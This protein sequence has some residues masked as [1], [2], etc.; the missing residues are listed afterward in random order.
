ME[1]FYRKLLFESLTRLVRLQQNPD[2]IDVSSSSMRLNHVRCEFGLHNMVKLVLAGWGITYNPTGVYLSYDQWT[3][4]GQTLQA[5]H[6]THEYYC[7]MLCGLIQNLPDLI[8][9]SLFASLSLPGDSCGLWGTEAEKV[10]LLMRGPKKQKT[11][12]MLFEQMEL[13]F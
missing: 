4:K 6:D 7:A 12:S 3:Q 9:P 11:G 2:I 8:R 13:V 5:P 1:T 10:F